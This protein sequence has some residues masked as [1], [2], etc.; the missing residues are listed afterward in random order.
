VNPEEEKEATSFVI[1][2]MNPKEAKSVPIEV[3][4]SE[5]E[6]EAASF[7]IDV[8][9]P[10]KAKSVPLN[11][12]NPEEEKEAAAV[13]IDVMSPKEEWTLDKSNTYM[14]NVSS[15]KRAYLLC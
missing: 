5:E 3:V 8:M 6:K 7:L 12:M 14:W 2:V 15:I 13:L 4:N 9:N 1:D 10:K 11:V